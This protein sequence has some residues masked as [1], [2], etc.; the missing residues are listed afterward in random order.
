MSGSRSAL[1]LLQKSYCESKRLLANGNGL[2]L[3][4]LLATLAYLL[5][6]HKL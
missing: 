4:R 3:A 6:R 5:N 1:R 2:E